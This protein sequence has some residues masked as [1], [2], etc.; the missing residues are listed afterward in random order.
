MSALDRLIPAPAL[1]E[2]DRLE[3]AVDGGRAWNAV[4]DL[5]LA[6]SPLVRTLFAIRT[7]PDRL[8]GK[9]T[10]L[11]LRLNDLVSTPAEPGF[12]VLIE[13]APHD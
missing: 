9:A 4:R 3:L 13:D 12:Q 2:I 8:Q 1:M 6:Q 10:Q 7:I 11:R 5:D